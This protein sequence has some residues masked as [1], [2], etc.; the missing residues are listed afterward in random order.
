ML[1]VLAGGA[2][3]SPWLAQD[4]ELMDLTAIFAPP[5]PEH[6]LG[7]DELGRDVLA[8]LAHGGRISLAVAGATAA[9]AAVIG[10]LL[11]LLA[12]YYGGRLDAALMRLTD[13]VM[14][15]PLLPLL[16]VLAAV[17][18]AKL[19]I[20]PE[21]L[22]SEAFAIAR[23]V[24]IIGAVGWT[25]V[26][27][28]VRAQTLSVK[29]RDYVRAA[30]AIGASPRRIMR[31]HILPNVASPVVVATT[32]SVANIILI[33]SALSFL[34][35][36]IR[37]PLASWG[38]MLTGAMSVVWS[39]PEQALWPGL[40]IFLTVLAFNLVGDGLQRAVDPRGDEG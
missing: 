7:T 18:P 30:T 28:L 2:V 40:A 3:L 32:L 24:L 13:G 38:N 14:S 9:L 35:L 34:G 5:S 20:P 22:G 23:I 29:A 15:L 4:P 31:R 10:T 11:G 37:P 1:A 39:A 36:G 12:G 21:Q 26:A 19:G 6:W 33:E 17:D 16:I 8:R 25:T 27:R